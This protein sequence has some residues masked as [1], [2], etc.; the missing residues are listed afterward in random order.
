MAQG[1]IDSPTLYDVFVDELASTLIRLGFGVTLGAGEPVPLLMYADDVVLLASSPDQLQRM[2]DAVTVFA[3][4][5][6]FSYNIEKSA[7]VVADAR[8]DPEPRSDARSHEWLL[9]GKTL[10]VLDQ[11]KY[12]GLEVGA[13]GAGRWSV[14]GYPRDPC[15]EGARPTPALV[16]WQSVRPVPCAPNAAVARDVSSTARVRLCAVGHAAQR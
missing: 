9:A 4:R 3:E 6:Q 11:Y 15:D 13:V 2:L 16:T 12:L 1:A 7:V 5:W 8:A 14:G 10:P